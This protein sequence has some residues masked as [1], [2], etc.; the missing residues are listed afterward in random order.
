MIIIGTQEVFLIIIELII[1]SII[2][3][4]LYKLIRKGKK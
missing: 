4:V 3:Y 2:L 1:L